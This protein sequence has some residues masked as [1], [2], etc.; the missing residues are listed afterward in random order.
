MKFLVFD[1]ETTGLIPK[2][3]D[4]INDYP[5]I[6]QLS[7]I[8]YDEEENKIKE[9]DYIIK[10]SYIP[11]ESSK[12]HRITT[13]IS[14][15]KGEEM[16]Y[17]LEQFIKDWNYCNMVIAHNLSFDMKMILAETQRLNLHINTKSKIYYCTMKNSIDL[18]K[19]EIKN[20]RKK[21]FYKYPKLYETFKTLYTKETIDESKLHNSLA[22]IYLCMI[23]FYKMYYDHDI[24]NINNMFKLKY[25]KIFK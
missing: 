16:K 14:Q 1:C 19:I 3:T 15:E 12:I 6:V 21:T 17:V 25:E 11:E 10:H 8:V 9:K 18:C 20:N 4:D 13:Q 24:R 5:H 7:W 23:C 2:Y 22:D